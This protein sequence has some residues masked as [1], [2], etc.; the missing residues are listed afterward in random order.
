[1]DI[2]ATTWC[3]SL[4]PIGISAILPAILVSFLVCMTGK[5]SFLKAKTRHA[6]TMM[7][8]IILLTLS[9]LK[10]GSPSFYLWSHGRSFPDASDFVGAY[11]YLSFGFGYSIHLL[12]YPSSKC[13]GIG[14]AFGYIFGEFIVAEATMKLLNFPKN[15][16]G[17][18]N[19][20]NWELVLTA[21]SIFA[22]V[23]IG[24][25]IAVILY[26]KK[27]STAGKDQ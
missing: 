21:M 3:P 6:L 5:Y 26:Q 1:M 16:L 14:L 2:L 12:R 27:R 4:D 7:A 8:P 19:I 9:A 24:M 13:L 10:V 20:A 23:W 17:G 18:Y 15:F 11:I 25:V 22:I